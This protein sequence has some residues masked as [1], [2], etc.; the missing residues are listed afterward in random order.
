MN[1]YSA[2]NALINAIIQQES[3]GNPK[4][5]SPAGAMGL[6]QVMP[7]T[8]ANPGFGVAPLKNPWNPVENRRFGTDY[9]NAMLNRYGGDKEA[10]LV[11]YNAGPGNADKFLAANRNYGVLP[12]RQETEPYVRNILGSLN[13]NNTQEDQMLGLS[14]QPVNQGQP[15]EFTGLLG[16]YIDPSLTQNANTG[17]NQPMGL[18]QGENDPSKPSWLNRNSDYLLALAAGILQGRTFGEG[19]G[20]GFQLVGG[21]ADK[22]KGQDFKQQLQRL[23]LQNLQLRNQG[24][25]SSLEQARNR[26]NLTIEYL[27]S[28]GVSDEEAQFMASNPSALQS[29]ITQNSSPTR[30]QILDEQLK[31]AQIQNQ[32]ST[33]TQ[34]QS[35]RNINAIKNYLTGR[36]VDENLATALANNPKA[37]SEYLKNNAA[38]KGVS[39]TKGEEAIDRA[40]AKDHVEFISGGS[41]DTEKNI[42][43]LQSVYDLLSSGKYDYLTGSFVGKVPDFINSMFPAG[44][45]AVAAR[46]DVEEV[47]QRNLR[48]VL[49]AAFTEKEGQRLIARAF[50]PSLPEKENARRLGR[51]LTQM[52]GAY[53]SKKDAADYFVKNGTLKGFKGKY[54]F[55]ISDFENALEDRSNS[56]TQQQQPVLSPGSRRGYNGQQWEYIGGDPA[57]PES[58]KRVQ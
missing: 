7:N 15:E 57:K 55:S 37:F 45:R 40:F 46:E 43:Q 54:H 21:V 2:S 22:E 19:L 16:N 14:A 1:N 26:Q 24:A 56:S 50:N 27:R 9:F 30:Q 5:L 32:Q 31:A 29:F 48:Q 58:W 47:V 52:K 8:A 38:N 12:R 6:M 11:A 34:D 28:K 18:L 53:N 25:Q 3:R 35:V 10:S 51:L 44:Q 42:R 23:Q 39:L 33:F 36:N 41:A 4:A 49:G 13:Q 17:Q 20:K